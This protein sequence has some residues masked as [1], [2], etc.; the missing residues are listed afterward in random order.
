M[1]TFPHSLDPNRT[2]LIRLNILYGLDHCRGRSFPVMASRTVRSAIQPMTRLAP[3]KSGMARRA[4]RPC[5]S[6]LRETQGCERKGRDTEGVGPGRGRERLLPEP[7][8]EA[9]HDERLEQRV[10]EQHL[11]ETVRR[12]VGDREIRNGSHGGTVALT[13]AV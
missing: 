3:M 7:G 11:H 8:H 6:P 2:F 4:D 1:N 5:L 9:Q 12:P 10:P 13:L